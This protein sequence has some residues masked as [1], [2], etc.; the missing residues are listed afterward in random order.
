MSSKRNEF[1][2]PEYRRGGDRRRAGCNIEPEPPSPVCAE[3]MQGLREYLDG[4]FEANAEALVHRTK[5]TDAHFLTLN[6]SQ[7]R[8][9]KDRDDY[10][11]HDIYKS[12]HANLVS[13]VEK[14][15]NKIGEVQLWRAGVEGKASR[16]NLVAVVA[17]IISVIFGLLHFYQGAK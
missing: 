17:I 7:A 6:N 13:R 1:G 12:E 9:D 10:L 14:L 8:L 4:R 11:R 5:E 15:S 2:E 3:K 16:S